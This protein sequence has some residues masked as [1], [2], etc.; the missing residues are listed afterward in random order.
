M[1]ISEHFKDYSQALKDM[2]WTIHGNVSELIISYRDG[3]TTMCVVFPKVTYLKALIG[4]VPRAV[5]GVQS[6]RFAVDLESI[7]TDKLRLY[8]DGQKEGELLR[9]FY[10]D[11]NKQMTQY[12]IYKKV[13]GDK[14]EVVIDRY[15][16]DGTLISNDEPELISDRDSWLGEDS[17]ADLADSLSGKYEVKYLKKGNKAQSYIRIYK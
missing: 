14:N 4:D 2:D 13:E 7:G 5:A 6:R 1:A 16:A 17:I 11:E 9:G 12:K 8:I 15:L 10:F 3:Q